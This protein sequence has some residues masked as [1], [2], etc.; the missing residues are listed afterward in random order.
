MMQTPM[1]LECAHAPFQV[2]ARS[3]GRIEHASMGASQ[4]TESADAA[5]VLIGWRGVRLV[6]G[7]DLQPRMRSYVGDI[8][9]RSALGYMTFVASGPGWLEQ[10]TACCNHHL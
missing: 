1:D 7:G 10:A 5:E 8:L 9:L 6:L 3:V 2:V 4:A